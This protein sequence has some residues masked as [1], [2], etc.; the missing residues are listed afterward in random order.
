[1]P[2]A[3]EMDGGGVELGFGVG[4]GGI[5]VEAVVVS[6]FADVVF[7]SLAHPRSVHAIDLM[8]R[9]FG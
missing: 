7:R 6:G 2:G 1:M 3:G 4:A 5:D 9:L 8:F